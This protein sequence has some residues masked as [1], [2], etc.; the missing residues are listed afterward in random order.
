M[1]KLAASPFRLARSDSR[2]DSSPFRLVPTPTW[3]I[4]PGGPRI[5]ESVAAALELPADATAASAEILADRG[6]MSSPSV[7]FVLDRLQQANAPRPCV[8]L[9]FGPGLVA[10]AALL[11]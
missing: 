1:W 4:H 5:I 10:E 7:L 6:N 8:A 9:A 11:V 2:F 3:A